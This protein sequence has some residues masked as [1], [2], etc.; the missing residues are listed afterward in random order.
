MNLKQSITIVAQIDNEQFSDKNIQAFAHD[1][2][3]LTRNW[4]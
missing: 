2:V 3:V 1:A 4:G